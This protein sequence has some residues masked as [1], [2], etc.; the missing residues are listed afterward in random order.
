[1]MQNFPLR[2]H[3]SI[4]LKPLW[5]HLAHVQEPQ[6]LDGLSCRALMQELKEDRLHWNNCAV[7]RSIHLSHR[8]ACNLQNTRSLISRGSG[9]L[10][11]GQLW[12]QRGSS[13]ELFKK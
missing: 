4:A 6:C 1:M 3:L 10:S 5:C 12:L 13:S 9:E 2:R 8:A 7:L 11:N